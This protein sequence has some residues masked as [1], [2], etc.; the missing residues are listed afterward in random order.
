M[1]QGK[2]QALYAI[3]NL[4]EELRDLRSME[5]IEEKRKLEEARLREEEEV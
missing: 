2:A 3:I 4:P 5:E 1:I